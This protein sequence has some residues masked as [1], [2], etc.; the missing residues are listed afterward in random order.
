MGET[1]L[2][3]ALL[4]PFQGLAQPA[5]LDPYPLRPVDT[6]SPRD[7]LRSFLTGVDKSFQLVRSGV[8]RESLAQQGGRAWETLDFSQVADRHLVETQVEHGLL[9]KEILDRIALP[10]DDQIPGDQEVADQG[11]TRWTLPDTRITVAR[12]KDGPREGEFLFTAHTVRRLK[13]MYRRAKHLPYQPGATEGIYAKYLESQGLSEAAV[14]QV[15]HRLKPVDTSSPRSTFAG[16][17]DSINRAHSLLMDADYAFKADPPMISRKEGLQ[18]EEEAD[19]LMQRAMSTLDLSQIPEANRNDLGLEAALQLK[20]V[21]DR[22]A[23]PHLDS[24]PDE[25]SVLDWRRD[26]EEMLSAT[27]RPFGWRFPNTEIEIVEV[28]DGPRTG[29]F[30]FSAETVSRAEAFYKRA[31]DLPYRPG[32][33]EGFYTFFISTPGY[34][35]PDAYP[36][37]RWIG[38]LPPMFMTVY[39]DQTVWQWVGLVLS[40]LAFIAGS[41]LIS[42]VIRRLSRRVG[43]LLHEWLRFLV[44]ILTMFLAFVINNFINDGLNITGRVLSIVTTLLEGAVY[45]LAGWAVFVLCKAVAQ[46]IVALPQIQEQSIDAS[47]WRIGG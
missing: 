12:V 16:F 34:L 10:P 3:L 2:L 40:M 38:N 30:L 18:V 6:S 42:S 9:L 28:Q 19:F 33:T 23:R 43:P 47:L 32:A 5:Y 29:E 41:V 22:I 36:L 11:I 15:R 39:A 20:E 35:V 17:W 44:P 25:D 8:P 31:Q 37:A 14:A 24:I 7:T 13:E 21:L 1:V 46:T 4:L 27:P 26:N 45:L